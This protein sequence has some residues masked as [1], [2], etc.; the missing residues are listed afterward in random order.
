M[1][2]NYPIEWKQSG[3][4]RCTLKALTPVRL[5]VQYLKFIFQ[6]GVP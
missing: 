5:V 1:P 3:V 2:E 4:N 6:L